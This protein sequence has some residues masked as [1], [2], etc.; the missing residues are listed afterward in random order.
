MNWLTLVAAGIVEVAWALS[1][2]P[3]ENF[4]RPLPTLLCIVLCLG[5]VYLLSRAMNT[6][7]VGTA[8]AVFTGIGAVGTI[9][10]GVLVN[11]D[12]LTA[13]R[14][15]ALALIVGGVMLARATA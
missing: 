15:A 14:V 5:A 11:K 1:I 8:Y 7:P 9:T 13:G 2:K 12:P 10:V 6:I 4:T 3:T